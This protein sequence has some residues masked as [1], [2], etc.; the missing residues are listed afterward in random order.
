MPV[1]IERRKLLATLGGVAAA[2]PLAARAQQ[3]GRVWRI[4]VLMP[5]AEG[6]RE[7]QLRVTA[8]RQ[9]LARLGW[10]EGRSLQIE[11]RWATTPDADSMRR[12]AKELVD[13]QPDLILT[14][15]TNLTAAVLQQTHTIPIVFVQVGD[16]VGSGFVT[17]FP[18]PG[19]NATGFTNIPLT[20][21]SKWLE[22]LMELVINL[23][24]AKALGLEI[25]PT[26]IARADEVIE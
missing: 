7:T 20:M 23:K 26:L 2:W 10:A 3:P 9:G 12:F 21:T 24:T 14:D 22:L 6:D 16:P 1:T 4:G 13:L 19:G 8:L 5:F 18:R 25:P 11:H 15:N 17:S